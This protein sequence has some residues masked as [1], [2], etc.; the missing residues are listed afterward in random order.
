M[1]VLI[2][3]L[4]KNLAVAGGFFLIIPWLHWPLT[5]RRVKAGLNTNAFS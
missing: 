1:D 5:C 3:G 2:K 4:A